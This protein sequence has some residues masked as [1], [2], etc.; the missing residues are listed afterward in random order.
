MK[1]E[2]SKAG[3]YC[4]TVSI[5]R[6]TYHPRT[7]EAG[8]GVSVLEC[9][10]AVVGYLSDMEVGIRK[11]CTVCTVAREAKQAEREAKKKQAAAA[12]APHPQAVPP[13]LQQL[14]LNIASSLQK[15]DGRFQDI[16]SRLTQVEDVKT[17]P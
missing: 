1:T 16:D 15:L 3:V 5:H 9:G 12:P 13:E 8:G 11:R 7:P 14:V 2:K 10:N 4:K 6:T 17:R